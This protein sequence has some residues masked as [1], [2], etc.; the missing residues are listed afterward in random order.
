VK[1]LIDDFTAR[2][3]AFG[4]GTSEATGAAFAR[5]R[6]PPHGK[7]QVFQKSIRRE[8]A[9]IHQTKHDKRILVLSETNRL[10]NIVSNTARKARAEK[11]K[12]RVWKSD[13][14]P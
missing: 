5:S 7:S 12:R 3:I 10:L 14:P 6:L 11:T 4:V 13:F 2:V 1:C 8:N 9:E